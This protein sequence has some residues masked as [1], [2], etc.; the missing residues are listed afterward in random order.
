MHF[1]SQLTKER[2][3]PQKTNRKDTGKKPAETRTTSTLA[4]SPHLPTPRTPFQSGAKPSQT[5]ITPPRIR[6]VGTTLS[7]QLCAHQPT[8]QADTPSANTA[9]QWNELALM[10]D[11]SS[12]PARTLNLQKKPFLAGIDHSAPGLSIAPLSSPKPSQARPSSASPRSPRRQGRIPSTGSRTLVMDVAQ[13]LQEAQAITEAE[14]T[15]KGPIP[16]AAPQQVELPALPIE[17]CKS[18]FDKFSG[19]VMPSLAEE[20]LSTRQSV[21]PENVMQMKPE[22]NPEVR[23]QEEQTCPDAPPPVWQDTSC[24]DIRE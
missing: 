2:P 21:N 13:A 10:G 7:T 24:I 19:R 18:D 12:D 9:D 11:R 3:K 17:N 14:V 20:N 23:R 22:I 8:S 16:F 5:P 4:N 1:S 6:A 15:T